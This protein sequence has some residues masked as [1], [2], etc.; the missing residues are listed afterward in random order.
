MQASEAL[1][2]ATAQPIAFDPQGDDV[3]KDAAIAA[4]RAWWQAHRGE[5]LTSSG[6]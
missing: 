1:Q 4:W 3:T 2:R 5:P 6:G